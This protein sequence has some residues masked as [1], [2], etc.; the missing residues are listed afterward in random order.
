MEFDS[1][2]V[3]T[4]TESSLLQMSSEDV[5][6]VKDASTKPAKDDAET[7]IVYVINYK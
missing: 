4:T 7:Y 6:I 1:F 2:K 5:N 3:P